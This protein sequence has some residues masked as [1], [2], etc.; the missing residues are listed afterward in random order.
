[1]KRSIPAIT[2]FLFFLLAFS[3]C[4][5]QP[6]LPQTEKSAVAVSGRQTPAAVPQTQLDSAR[7]DSLLS[8][9]IKLE[10]DVY[11]GLPSA[12]AD[13]LNELKKYSFDSSSGC[14]L[15]VGKGAFNKTFPE[16]AW[17]KGR[18]MAASYD[19]KRWALYLKAWQEGSAIVFGNKI[20]GEVTYS[21]ILLERAVGDTLYQLIQVP[22]GSVIVK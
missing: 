16:G 8:L 21:R 14:F 19:G 12:S 2:V 13:F 22:I 18:K 6:S 15:T 4:K 11:A 3:S 20:S 7:C 10:N 5:L 17:D 9:L 1:M